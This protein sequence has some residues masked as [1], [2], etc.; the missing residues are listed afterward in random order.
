MMKE[1]MMSNRIGSPLLLN[2]VDVFSPSDSCWNWRSKGSWLSFYS[3]S[4]VSME[5]VFLL[6]IFTGT[7]WLQVSEGRRKN[8][9]ISCILFK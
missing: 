1:V 9:G 2:T 4:V 3:R 7:N 5:N 6:V 8:Y